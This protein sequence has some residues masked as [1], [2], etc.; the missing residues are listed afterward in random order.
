M[1][2]SATIE[3]LWPPRLNRLFPCRYNELVVRRAVFL[4]AVSLLLCPALRAQQPSAWGRTLVVIP[5]ENTSSAPGLDW[6]GEGFAEA[7]RSQL[8]SPV[9]YVATREERLRAYDRQGI[10]GGLH[11]SRAT[12]LS[13]CRTDGR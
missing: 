12:V 5:F 7:L 10:P 1:L 6:L 9:L 2:I 3:K 4:L 8:D 11:P 13:A